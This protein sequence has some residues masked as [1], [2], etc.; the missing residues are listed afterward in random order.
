MRRIET[1]NIFLISLSFLVGF[2]ATIIPLPEWAIWLRPQFIFAILLFWTITSS[3]QCGI[4]TAFFVGILMD[5]ILGTPIGVH[6]LSFVILIYIALKLHTIIAHFPAIQQAGAIAIF[7]IMN[8]FLQS[9]VLGFAGHSTHV[10]LS[11]LSAITTAMLWPWL[12]GLLDRLRPR[13]MIM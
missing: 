13:A 10:G 11:I 5:L 2:I 3:S 4:A 9:M 7:A 12:F 1:T 6:A 8:I